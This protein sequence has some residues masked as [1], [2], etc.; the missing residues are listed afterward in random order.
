MEWG[1]GEIATLRAGLEPNTTKD[2]ERL[3]RTHHRSLTKASVVIIATSP[4][5][6]PIR[7]VSC[8]VPDIAA[9]GLDIHLFPAGYPMTQMIIPTSAV[10]TVLA[11][12]LVRGQINPRKFLTAQDLESLRILFPRAIGAQLLM[13][14]FLR[15][16]FRNSAD[17]ES[18]NKLGYLGEVGGLAVLLDTAEFSATAQNIESGTALIGPE[19]KPIGCLGLKLKL[20]GE[21]R[22]VITAV[23]HAFVRT[24]VLPAVV[25][26]VADWVVRAKKAI[27]KF[28]NPHLDKDSRFSDY[29]T[30][31]NTP[32]GKEITL[33]KTDSKVLIIPH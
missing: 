32:V 21:S 2:N 9:G 10:R 16:L 28:W 1:T 15:I 7:L 22:T 25:M 24:P 33:M 11:Q 14:G 17:V 5:G 30:L 19:A 29:G 4:F 27:C 20:P 23:T 12:S 18:S 31:S 26:R 13:A 3:L 6:K 8:N